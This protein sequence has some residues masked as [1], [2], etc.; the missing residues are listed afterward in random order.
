MASPETAN[1]VDQIKHINREAILVK[2]LPTT[3]RV[4]GTEVGPTRY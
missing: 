1:L 2:W 4:Y 3:H